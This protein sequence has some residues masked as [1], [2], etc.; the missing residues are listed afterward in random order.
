[1]NTLHSAAETLRSQ[2]ATLAQ[3][4]HA[5]EQGKPSTSFGHHEHENEATYVDSQ[6]H[7]LEPSD[8]NPLPTYVAHP[9][10]HSHDQ[11]RMEILTLYTISHA[12]HDPRTGRCHRPSK[13]CR[14]TSVSGT[15]W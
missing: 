1:M 11:L 9:L 15:C 3:Q 14:A 4:A 7:L 12:C 6:R 13:R 2:L 5:T 8:Y 10:Q